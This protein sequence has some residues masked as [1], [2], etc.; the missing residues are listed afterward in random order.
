[1]KIE[2]KTQQKNKLKR[3]KIRLSTE[4]QKWKN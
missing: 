4:I 2:G 3:K 1:M